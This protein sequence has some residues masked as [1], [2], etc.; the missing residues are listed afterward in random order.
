MESQE[1]NRPRRIGFISTRVSGTDGVSLEINKWA[2]VLDRMGHDCFYITG[3]SDRP[4]E[5]TRLIPEAH[6]KH[7]TIE[8]I[9]REAFAHEKRTPLLA[10]LIHETIWVI[11]QKLWTAIDDL[12][13]DIIIA[14]NCCTIPINIPLGVAVVEAFMEMD[15]GCIAH[16]HDFY[17]ERER[18]MLN[19]VDDYLRA[20][21][22]PPLS[23]MQHV[24]ISTNA[25][26]EFSR[27]TGLS[28][29]VVPNVMDF[30]R[31][32]QPPD[33][34]SRDFRKSL[35][36][37]EDDLVILQ[38]TRVIARKGIEHSIQLIRLLGDPRCKLV[39][40]H[41]SSDEGEAYS[42]YIKRFA[43]MLGV[44]VIL[45]EGSISDKRGTGPDGAKLY[46]IEDAYQ[47]AD[48]VTYPSVY[49]GFGN[50]FLE[51]IYYK[52]PLL[53][54]RYTI[55]RVDLEPCGFDVVLMDGFL[56]DKVVE[57]VHKV[58]TDEAFRTE[59]VGHN[60]EVAKQYFSYSRLETE[61]RA[62]LA[63]PRMAAHGSPH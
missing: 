28:C 14:E 31:P 13:L 22:P 32:P 54:N 48:F 29:R 35:G 20:A 38:P 3:R 18:F 49:E 8:Q 21:F 1:I 34:Y 47:H 24:A 10:S 40:T 57:R 58:L 41:M 56:T 16:H 37:A 9:T 42:A 6:L 5:R 23:Q 55:Y 30:D 62:M 17:W 45:A 33:D 2:E 15:V 53:C 26:R 44:D 4:A 59:M 36:I 50:A 39:V 63:K 11:K 19:A 12:Q 51:A 25:A 61:L 27:R 7:P 60:Y 52:K 46:T 43:S